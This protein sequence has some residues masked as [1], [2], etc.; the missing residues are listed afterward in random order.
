LPETSTIGATLLDNGGLKLNGQDIGH[1][2]EVT[3]GDPDLEYWMTVRASDL[4][5]TLV[6]VL[7]D[8]FNRSGPLT[9][10]S[11]AALLE[12]EGIDTDRGSWT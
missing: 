6:A 3:W 9:W 4:R 1:S 10:A 7:R 2:V 8:G 11:L 12:A 5:H